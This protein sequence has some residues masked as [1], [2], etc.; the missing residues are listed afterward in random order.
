MSNLVSHF[1]MRLLVLKEG[2]NQLNHL[3]RST[4]TYSVDPETMKGK[5]NLDEL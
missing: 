3:Q 5:I 1:G 2:V 4:G